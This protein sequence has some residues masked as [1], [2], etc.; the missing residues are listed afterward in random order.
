MQIIILKS[1]NL[2]SNFLESN[3]VDPHPS[4]F[5]NVTVDP[6]WYGFVASITVHSQGS[7]RKT[8]DG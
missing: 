5:K 7:L 2:Y 1:T 8:H 6:C 4:R 3:Y